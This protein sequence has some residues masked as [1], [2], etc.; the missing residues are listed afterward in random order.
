[1]SPRLV[2]PHLHPRI[3]RLFVLRP[4]SELALL[5]AVA[6][7][8]AFAAGLQALGWLGRLFAVV[9][10]QIEC[11]RCAVTGEQGVQRSVGG[12]ATLGKK[13]RRLTDFILRVQLCRPEEHAADLFEAFF[14]SEVKCSASC[15]LSRVHLGWSHAGR[16]RCG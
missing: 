6:R 9:A 15:L 12:M 5:A 3:A 7:G 8:I 2:L 4:G 1:M 14:S 16:S 13:E 10:P 11:L